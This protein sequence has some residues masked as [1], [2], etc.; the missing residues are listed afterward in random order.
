[1]SGLAGRIYNIVFRK[2]ALEKVKNTIE[3]HMDAID[4]LGGS[5]TMC[6]NIL[7]LLEREPE[8]F[9]KILAG[10]ATESDTGLPTSFILYGA[11]NSIMAAMRDIHVEGDDPLVEQR[12]KRAETIFKIAK[13]VSP[14][15]GKGLT[16]EEA[17]VAL[18]AR[19]L[20]ADIA[21]AKWRVQDPKSF[22]ILS[23]A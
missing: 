6:K 5:D 8:L 19:K 23:K 22:T 12:L 11:T 7:A 18:E 15:S 20:E 4:Q 17:I 1:M 14:T 13:M 10:K 3:V 21:I 16:D 9:D 2:R